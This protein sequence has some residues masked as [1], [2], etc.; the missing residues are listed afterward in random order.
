MADTCKVSGCVYPMK[1]NNLCNRHYR[2]L[3]V[4]GELVV[5]D[6]ETMTMDV[7]PCQI[8]GCRRNALSKDMCQLHYNRKVRFGD[9]NLSRDPQKPEPSL[10]EKFWSKVEKTDGCWLW[11]GMKDDYGKGRFGY[12][13][14]PRTAHGYSYMRHHELSEPLGKGVLL[15]QTCG[16]PSCVRPEHLVRITPESAA[17]S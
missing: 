9:P 10:D 16:E 5:S 1:T 3:R 6:S 11:T 12:E 14:K 15:H 17:S 13:G 8:E 7:S 4:T 2:L